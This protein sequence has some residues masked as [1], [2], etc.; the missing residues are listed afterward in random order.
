MLCNNNVLDDNNTGNEGIACMY[1][2]AIIY[3]RITS[4]LLFQNDKDVNE[5]IW[6]LN[7]KQK[8]NFDYI[9]KWAKEKVKHKN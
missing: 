9:S 6:S 3:L 2:S 8:Q 4:L 7:V 1:Q 5:S